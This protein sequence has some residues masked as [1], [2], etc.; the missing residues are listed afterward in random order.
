M[1]CASICRISSLGSAA[2]LLELV[3]GSSTWMESVRYLER[4]SKRRYDSIE[5]AYS[6]EMVACC[7]KDTCCGMTI[8][9][10]FWTGSSIGHSV[11]SR[12]A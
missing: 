9:V 10:G 5:G 3:G 8:T 6:I 4:E 1:V 7:S 2:V 11:L 12:K